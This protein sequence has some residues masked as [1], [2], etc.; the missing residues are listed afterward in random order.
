M[1]STDPS[2]MRSCR[3]SQTSSR[4]PTTCSQDSPRLLDF[5][6][7]RGDLGA[8]GMPRFQPRLPLKL[9]RKY[10]SSTS[11]TPFQRFG[12]SSQSASRTTFR[13]RPS[14]SWETPTSPNLCRTSRNRCPA[15]RAW[16][17]RDHLSGLRM[18][19]N[20][21][22]ALPLKVRPHPPWEGGRLR[23]RREP[24]ESRPCL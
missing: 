20:G 12:S 9:S 22:P 24:R 17:N 15:D 1:Y 19:A 11:A 14:V 13:Q 16:R 18:R 4:Y 10:V 6:L 7:L 21:V 8:G 2:S 5:P 3:A 23:K